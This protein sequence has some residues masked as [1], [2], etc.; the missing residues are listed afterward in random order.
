MPRALWKGAISFGLVHVP[1]ALYAASS[2]DDIDFDWLDKRSMDPVGYQRINKRTGKEVD[3]EHIVKGVKVGDGEY[4]VLGDDEIKA[5]YPKTTQTIALQGFV[6]PAQIPFT[7]LERP[8]YLEP[9]ARAQKVYALL[10]EALIAAGAVGIARFVLHSKEHLAVLAPVGPA[11]LLDTLRWAGEVR[12]WTELELPAAGRKA[13]GVDDAELKLAGQ[14]ITQMTTEWNADDYRNEFTGALRK[15]IEQRVGA[16]QTAAVESLEDAAPVAS[17]G[18]VV[19]LSELLARSL[20]R[21]KR[22]EKA[23]ATAAR[24]TAARTTAAPRKAPARKRA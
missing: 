23:G 1:V 5:A 13:S 6:D 18:N 2:E 19:D 16:G 3:K 9:Q 15:L 21:E 8:Y 11:L 20:K 10:R 17:S 14:L 4:V 12:P 7:L 24:K 22:G